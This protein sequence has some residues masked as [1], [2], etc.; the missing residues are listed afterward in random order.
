[1][2][3]SVPLTREII[4]AAALKIA[5]RDGLE[6]L[7]MRALASEL[8][9]T[10]MATYY[11]VPDKVSL[12]NL[13]VDAVH[14]RQE[15]LEIGPDGWEESLRRRLQ[16]QWDALSRYPGLGAYLLNQPTLGATP[17]A[18]NSGIA[19]FTA[20]GFSPR[21]AQLA[22]SFSTTYLHGRL[23]VDA[24][25][26]GTGPAVVTGIRARE[27]VSFGIDAVIL[28]LK[29]MLDAELNQNESEDSA[30]AS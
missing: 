6:G 15:P 4:V 3:R 25:L 11:H 7:T 12:V 22:W 20:V 26:R 17:T 29:A 2:G 24:R 8:G 13:V 27:Y 18:I 16:S 5:E 30:A 21:S 19:F 23:S 9:V 28:G 14:E 1:M 10:P